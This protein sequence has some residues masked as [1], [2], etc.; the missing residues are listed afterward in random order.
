M[1]QRGGSHSPWDFSDDLFRRIFAQN[2]PLTVAKHTVFFFNDNLDKTWSTGLRLGD[3][4]RELRY[5]FAFL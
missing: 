1:G 4:H 3:N 2:Q 5:R